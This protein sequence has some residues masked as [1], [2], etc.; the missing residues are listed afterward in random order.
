MLVFHPNKWDD[1]EEDDEDDAA[2]AA[3]DD[4]Q[5]TFTLFKSPTTQPMPYT[6]FRYIHI[7]HIYTDL[8]NLAISH[9]VN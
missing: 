7:Y 2:A 9:V 4:S 3:D 5:L 1:D 8:D 6:C